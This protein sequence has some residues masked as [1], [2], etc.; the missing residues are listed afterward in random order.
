MEQGVLV[1]LTV[2]VAFGVGGQ[3]LASRIRVPSIL[4]LLLAGFIAGPVTGLVDPDAMFGDLLFPAVSLATGLLL[5]DSGMSLKLSAL[6]IG[7][8]PVLRLVTLGVLVTWIVGSVTA[9]LV[10]DLSSDLAVLLGA[11]L[12]VSGPT[13][14]IPILRRLRPRPPTGPILRWEGTIIDPIGASLGVVVL[15]VVLEEGNLVRDTVLGVAG[16]AVTGIAVG[17]GA[18]VLVLLAL[19]YYRSPDLLRSPVAV[20]MAVV[21]FT[22]TNL[23]FDEGG[24]FATTAFG[25][26]LA[27]QRRVDVDDIAAFEKALGAMILGALFVLLGARIE[28]S[29]LAE[30][31]VAGI[32]LVFV[33][34]LVA[35]PLAVAVSVVGTEVSFREGAFLAAM[36]PRGIVAAATSSVFALALSETGV[37]GADLLAPLTFTVIIGTGVVYGLG[38]GPA[39][40]R[41]GVAGSAPRGVAL[42]GSQPWVVRLG[43]ELVRSDVP[44]LLMPGADGLS[45]A[46]LPQYTGTWDSE[47]FVDALGNH[48]IGTALVMSADLEHNVVGVER[49]VECLGAPNVY[50]LPRQ[51]SGD[52]RVP[53]ARRPFGADVSQATITERTAAG[54]RITTLD[55][56]D[57]SPD[58]S[59]LPLIQV[60]THGRP[61]IAPRHTH[62]ALAGTI[63]LTGVDDISRD[64]E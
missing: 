31:W 35:R 12:V 24:L 22:T 11:I 51:A 43:E 26:A 2:I 18:A 61:I 42:V 8:Q 30:V 7:R 16:A 46:S 4:V 28:L 14:V 3:W 60:D 58:G 52:R 45:D 50:Y 25:I 36:A 40:R 34:V 55:P 1:G 54:G 10:T 9:F 63:V 19:R 38:A 59:S 15:T 47:E 53:L 39:A 20:A 13:V 41:L 37:A 32:V 57:E 27:N 21:A 23:L 29:E 33:L 62:H 17:L 6:S 56:E 5:F 49:L 48:D 44:V 64:R